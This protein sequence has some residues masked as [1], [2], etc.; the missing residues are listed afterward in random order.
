MILNYKNGLA[1]LE[2]SITSGTRSRLTKSIVRLVKI[3][4]KVG[5][6]LVTKDTHNLTSLGIYMVISNYNHEF[7]A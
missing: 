7:Q 4:L 2:F 5:L 6:D 3:L 1:A